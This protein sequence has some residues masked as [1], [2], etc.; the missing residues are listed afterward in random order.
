ML[1]IILIKFI[2][3]LVLSLLI[4]IFAGKIGLILFKISYNVSKILFNYVENPVILLLSLLFYPFGIINY[5]DN[6]KYVKL[7]EEY[8]SVK[9]VCL[10]GMMKNISDSFVRNGRYYLPVRIAAMLSFQPY[11]KALLSDN[12]VLFEYK[13]HITNQFTDSLSKFDTDIIAKTFFSF[14]LDPEYC[15]NVKNMY[16]INFT[17]NYY[18]D[19]NDKN[20]SDYNNV[21]MQVTRFFTNIIFLETLYKSPDDFAKGI[22]DEVIHISLMNKENPIYENIRDNNLKFSSDSMDL[23]ND[24][25][26]CLV[27]L[28]LPYTHLNH[29]VSCI[30][31]EATY[32]LTKQRYEHPMIGIKTNAIY[33]EYTW[34]IIDK[35]FNDRVA[36]YLEDV[37]E[38]TN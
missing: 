30:S 16:N 29:I 36:G 14:M 19:E 20:Y 23:D 24:L 28:R 8:G 12:P 15:S 26:C 35:L 22:R 11:I 6:Q 25:R 32:N 13:M 34:K 7:F 5:L 31:V 37:V 17:P 2:F 9:N 1:P 21:G 10:D 27:T 3:F 33:S 4:I 18:N 38:K